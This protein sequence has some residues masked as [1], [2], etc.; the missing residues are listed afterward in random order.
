MPIQNIS[1][2]QIK[3]ASSLIDYALGGGTASLLILGYLYHSRII[4]PKYKSILD[5]ISGFATKFEGIFKRV[6]KA[7]SN[8]TEDRQAFLI[9]QAE[10]REYQKHINEAIHRVDE[11]ESKIEDFFLDIRNKYKELKTKFSDIKQAY[12]IQED[13][14]TDL[15]KS[16]R[17][18]YE[19]LKTM[20]SDTKVMENEI[21]YLRQDMNEI[22]TTLKEL[23]KNFEMFLLEMA[24][25]H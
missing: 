24:K 21:K 25:K 13:R 2:D 20:S 6:D 4:E 1:P 9:S 8:I 22:K 17:R 14:I 19:E 3:E 15:E 5:K 10:Y 23:A 12:K 7:E 11:A 16:E 18:H